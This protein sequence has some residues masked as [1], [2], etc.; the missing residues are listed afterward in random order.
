[1]TTF[2]S[3]GPSAPKAGAADDVLL[4]SAILAAIMSEAGLAILEPF[5]GYLAGVITLHLPTFCALN[6]PDDPG[7]SGADLL[8]LVALGPGPLTAGPAARFSQLVQRYAWF[9]YC[10]CT[11]VTT[12]APPDPPTITDVPAINP[13]SPPAPTIPPC[14]SADF[15]TPDLGFAES[16]ADITFT[17]GI[18]TL[19]VASVA[20]ECIGIGDCSP[21][22]LT[23][24]PSWTDA[25]GDHS[26][27]L[28]PSV[29][30]TGDS[31]IFTIVP[32]QVATEV[33]FFL[34]TEE[35]LGDLNSVR[36]HV[37]IYCN[38]AMPGSQSVPCCPPD[39]I[40]TAKLDNILSLVT[41]LQRQ[42]APFSY[43]T[44]AVHSALTDTGAISV[45]G[46]LG[47][48]A[49]ITVPDSMSLVEG[50]PAVHLRPGRINMGTADGFEDRHEL[51][52]GDQLV[53]PRAAGLWTSVGYTLAPGVDLVLTELIREP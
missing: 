10:E 21:T 41:L 8:A 18:P 38:G 15:G 19:F 12:P 14:Y 34:T 6:P 5:V 46:I 45:Q 7:L 4:T 49:S 2:C 25:L 51:V 42:I 16:F 36:C 27:T 22:W 13:N 17:S 53:F 26:S 11:T 43:V 30:D 1:L 40:M 44:G 3:G 52:I 33:N 24:Q 32:P 50:T 37:D 9:S 20:T 23:V 35:G 47:L 28:P 39:P 31:Q 48:L 29:V